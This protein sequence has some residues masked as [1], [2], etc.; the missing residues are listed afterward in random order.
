MGMPLF[1]RMTGDR[2]LSHQV[3]VTFNHDLLAIFNIE[4]LLWLAVETA[5]LKVVVRSVLVVVHRA[6]VVN[7]R[8]NALRGDDGTHLDGDIQ[9]EIA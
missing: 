7:G 4:S 2:S 6:D 9:Q 5:P 1:R 8:Y 3:L